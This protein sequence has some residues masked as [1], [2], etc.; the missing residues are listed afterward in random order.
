MASREEKLKFAESAHLKKDIPEFKVG[1]TVNVHVKIMEDEKTRTQTFEGIVIARKGSGLRSSFTVRKISFGEGVERIFQAHSPFVEK[2]TVVK[3]GAVKR[4]KL[5]YL[6][7]KIGKATKVEEK[8]DA[9][10]ES[11][12]ALSREQVPEKGV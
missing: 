10:L 7:K 8:I 1:D 3:R 4:S 5:Y 12:D 6:R 9:G 2:I 11:K